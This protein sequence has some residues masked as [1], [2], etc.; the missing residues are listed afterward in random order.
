MLL[1]L[2][3]YLALAVAPTAA[4]HEGH[5]VIADGAGAVRAWAAKDL[6]LDAELTK[7]LSGQTVLAVVAAP[8]T[9]WGFDASR[10][11]RWDDAGARW[12]PVPSTPPAAP[13]LAFAVVAGAPV[14]VTQ[15]SVHRFTDGRVFDAPPFKDQLEGRGFGHGPA[16]LA[17]HGSQPALG[18]SFGEWGGFLWLLDVAS[19][20]WARHYDSLGA[21]AG[22][23]WTGAAWA[24]AWSMSHFDASTRVRLHGVDGAPTREGPLLSARYLRALAWDDEG[25][26]LFGLERQQVVR[27]EASLDLTSLHRIGK[28]AYGPERN[29]IGVSPGVAAFQVL[30]GGGLLL[31][32][33]HGDAV[34]IARGKTSPLRREAPREPR[35]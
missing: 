29:A 3:A 5:L 19:G 14:C 34:V 35:R 1:A 8:G 22:I 25:K 10:P 2:A 23:A 31:V 7:R 6:S 20:A 17:T 4:Q 9:L 33:H 30:Q 24:V 16:V 27:V 26:A 32:P 11:F 18:V 12:E 15:A 13:C 21:P 28:V